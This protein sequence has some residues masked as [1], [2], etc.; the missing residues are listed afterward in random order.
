MITSNWWEDAIENFSPIFKNFFLL[1]SL[2][3]KPSKHFI[4]GGIRTRIKFRLKFRFKFIFWINI[5]F[6]RVIGLILKIKQI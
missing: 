1:Q 4:R 2:I 5:V 3:G 6:K